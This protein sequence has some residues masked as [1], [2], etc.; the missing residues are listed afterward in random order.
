MT[1]AQFLEKYKQPN[2]CEYPEAL[3]GDMGCWSL[4][5]PG[6]IQNIESCKN[7]ELCVPKQQNDQAQ[8]PGGE[9]H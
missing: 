1:W 7:C 5:T 8:R 4:M 3:M 6:T 9:G 2:W